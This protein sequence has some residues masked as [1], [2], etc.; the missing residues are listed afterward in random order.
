MLIV[1]LGDDDGPFA[2]ETV[3]E[4]LASA[5]FTWSGSPTEGEDDPTVFHVRTL[6]VA[7]KID[8]D[9]AADR[10]DIVKEMFGDRFPILTSRPSAA[11]GWRSCGRGSSNFST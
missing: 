6:L 3:I 10:L 2:A 8:A 5:R 7:N 1:D 9:G 4:R 11:T